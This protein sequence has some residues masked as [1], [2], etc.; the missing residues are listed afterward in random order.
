MLDL[1]E[2]SLRIGGKEMKDLSWIYSPNNARDIDRVVE[3]RFFGIREIVNFPFEK[4]CNLRS[5]MTGKETEVFDINSLSKCERLRELD[6]KGGKSALDFNL[7]LEIVGQLPKQV[8]ERLA[9]PSW[10]DVLRYRPDFF[11]AIP[12]RRFQDQR[13]VKYCLDRCVWG[14]KKRG[15]LIDDYANS[16]QRKNDVALYRKMRARIKEELGVEMIGEVKDYTQQQNIPENL[17]TR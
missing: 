7:N 1:K 5:V 3:I 6:V 4:F 14:M 16:E 11:F 15:E 2:G 17:A 9:I 8:A 10:L 13:F 12:E